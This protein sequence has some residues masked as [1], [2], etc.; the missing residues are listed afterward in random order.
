MTTHDSTAVDAAGVNPHTTG[1]P[2]ELPDALRDTPD[3][4]ADGAGGKAR[5]TITY[6]D[7]GAQ[8]VVEAPNGWLVRRVVAEGYERLGEIPRA[9]DRIE[10]NGASLDAVLDL[11]VKE[12]VEQGI[13][14]DL[15]LNIVSPTGG[16]RSCVRN[17]AASPRR[18]VAVSL[19]TSA[20]AVTLR[21][22]AA[23]VTP[24]YAASV[25]T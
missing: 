6:D 8:V 15:Q 22:S 16:A 2:P 9:G 7:T 19:R 5:F 1:T 20:A 21:T 25:P 3:E 10:A 17:D 24:R 14:P 11:R 13:A 18:L 23:A 4:R 12:F